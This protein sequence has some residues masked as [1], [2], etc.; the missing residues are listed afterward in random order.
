MAISVTQPAAA[1][2]AAAAPANPGGVM[3]K[4]SFMKLLVAAVK[5]QDRTDPVNAREM[6]PHRSH[7]SSVEKLTSVDSTLQTLKAQNAGA[8]SVQ[9]AGLVG[10][11][12]VADTN[13]MSLNEIGGSN[14][15]YQ[16][17]GR[18]E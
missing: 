6:I 8:A 5:A 10:R 7:V 2:S 4:A 13:R 14:G 18:A 17:E 15:S 16:L 11:S 9:S 3:G 12:I 1:Q